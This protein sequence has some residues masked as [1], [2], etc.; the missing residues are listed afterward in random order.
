MK[1]VF[2]TLSYMLLSISN[3]HA[4]EKVGEATFSWLF[5]DI[6]KI[7]LWAENGQYKKSKFPAKLNIQYFKDIDRTQ[8]IDLTEE[9]WQ[10]QNLTYQESWL[11]E[12]KGIWPNIQTNDT[13][14]VTVSLQGESIFHHNDRYLGRISDR[15][16]SNKFLAIWLSEN[17]TEP[18]LRQQLIGAK[19]D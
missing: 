9:Q 12:L 6:Y 19:N 1:T 10:A 2:Y 18:S 17:T 13:L 11:S 14:S 5:W 15:E 8:L 16:F 4:L 7:S 3:S